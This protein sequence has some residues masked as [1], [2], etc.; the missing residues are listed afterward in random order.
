MILLGQLDTTLQLALDKRALSTSTRMNLRLDHKLLRNGFY[1]HRSIS[2]D[3]NVA[4]EIRHPYAGLP[5]LCAPRQVS[6]QHQNVAHSLQIYRVAI[7]TGT[8]ADSASGVMST[9]GGRATNV[10]EEKMIV[11]EAVVVVLCRT[12]TFGLRQ[13]FARI[14][15]ADTRARNHDR[16]ATVRCIF[17]KVLG[18]AAVSVFLAQ[19]R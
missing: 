12:F 3:A 16:A 8:R 11:C 18:V 17:A 15:S 10:V 2:K 14:T 9:A 19:S 13:T 4:F 5:R 1:K 7:W 6:P